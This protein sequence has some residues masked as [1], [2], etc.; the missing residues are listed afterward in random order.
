VPIC[1][2]TRPKLNQPRFW[3]ESQYPKQIR[4]ANR[5]MVAGGKYADTGCG[6]AA[7]SCQHANQRPPTGFLDFAGLGQ[8]Y[9]VGE[10]GNSTNIR[11]S[12]AF[13]TPRDSFCW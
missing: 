11:G 2:A 5:E 3:P 1:S 13:L 8:P 9:A 12:Y 6:P 10:R 4:P 7:V